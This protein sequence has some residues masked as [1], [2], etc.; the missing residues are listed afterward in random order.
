MKSRTMK[1]QSPFTVPENSLKTST[2]WSTNWE[3][4]NGTPVREF[5]ELLNATVLIFYVI[6]CSASGF[7]G[8]DNPN[9]IS[10]MSLCILCLDSPPHWLSSTWVSFCA[11]CIEDFETVYCLLSNSNLS[12]HQITQVELIAFIMKGGENKRSTAC[13]NNNKSPN[14]GPE[15]N[16]RNEHN[17]QTNGPPEPALEQRSTQL[18]L[19]SKSTHIN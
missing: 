2:C 8:S 15:T 16:H 18:V 10:K 12:L 1:S 9:E 11:N 14:Q 13:R 4:Q 5:K 7:C 17:V 6:E 19:P 3:W